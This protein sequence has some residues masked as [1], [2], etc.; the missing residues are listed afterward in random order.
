MRS[1]FKRP[2]I[3]LVMASLWIGWAV[4]ANA[5]HYYDAQ[6]ME[7]EIAAVLGHADVNL[8]PAEAGFPFAYMRYDYSDSN[9]LSIHATDLSVLLPNVLF[10]LAGTF[11]VALLVVRMRRMSLL[12]IVALCC[13]V[14][15]AAFMSIRL[16]GLHPTVMSC[17]YLVPLILLMMSLAAEAIRGGRVRSNSMQRSSASGVY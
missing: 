4:W 6:A 12:G 1:R 15:P 16:N 7:R 13:L 11:G 5:P 10:S 8:Q 2:A 14:A 9:Q 3:A 17:L